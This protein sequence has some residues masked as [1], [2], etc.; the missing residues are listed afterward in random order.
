MKLI[1]STGAAPLESLSVLTPTVWSPHEH[2]SLDFNPVPYP[3]DWCLTGQR[4]FLCSTLPVQKR[5]VPFAYS[6]FGRWVT[7]V[8]SLEIPFNL[9]FRLHHYEPGNTLC[10]FLPV[11]N[12]RFS[13]NNTLWVTVTFTQNRT[14]TSWIRS[15]FMEG[16]SCQ[17]F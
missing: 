8:F 16:Q 12:T 2:T 5:Q 14:S 1:A 7:S 3:L 11:T 4:P 6:G 13:T 17:E 10:I 9:C 15:G